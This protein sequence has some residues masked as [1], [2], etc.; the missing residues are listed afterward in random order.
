MKVK[1]CSLMCKVSHS[2]DIILH[3]IWHVE[4]GYIT[5]ECKTLVWLTKQILICKFSNFHISTFICM[6]DIV[7]LFIN[8]KCWILHTYHYYDIEI[9]TVIQSLKRN[10]HTECIKWHEHT[11]YRVWN[12][13]VTKKPAY[14]IKF[15]TL[16]AKPGIDDQTVHFKTDSPD[17]RGMYNRSQQNQFLPK[18][19]QESKFNHRCVHEMKRSDYY[20]NLPVWYVKLKLQ[21]VL[22]QHIQGHLCTCQV[23]A[24]KT[25]L[26]SRNWVEDQMPPSYDAATRHTSTKPGAPALEG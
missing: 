6:L 25:T 23:K 10:Y 1:V 21:F 5:L 13:H 11:Y 22:T 8:I 17:S 24:W 2:Y 9:P 20:K 3:V 4:F 19:D 7:H 15:E 26:P 14:G 16:N 18:N 12:I